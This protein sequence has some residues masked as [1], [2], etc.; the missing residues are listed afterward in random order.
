M[1]KKMTPRQRSEARWGLLFVAPTIIGL[2]IL[3][4]YPIVETVWQSLCKT[5]DFGMGN[6]FI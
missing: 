1:R 5:G 4:Y 3:N 2:L 6:E